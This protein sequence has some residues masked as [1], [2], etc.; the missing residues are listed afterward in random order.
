MKSCLFMSSQAQ[1]TAERTI[2]KNGAL[3]NNFKGYKATTLLSEYKQ[4]QEIQVSCSLFINCLVNLNDR[5]N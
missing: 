4:T 5:V 1:K 3:K 2:L